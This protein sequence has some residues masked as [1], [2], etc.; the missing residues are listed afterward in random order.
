MRRKWIAEIG[1]CGQLKNVLTYQC[2]G[3]IEHMQCKQHHRQVNERVDLKLLYWWPCNFFQPL[4]HWTES[5]I[6]CFVLF[7]FQN[8]IH[9]EC[10]R[11][12][13]HYTL[14]LTISTAVDAVKPYIYN[15]VKKKKKIFSICVKPC[16]MF[17]M[18]H[19]H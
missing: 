7:D 15:F 5:Y 4:K 8:K 10:E 18:I 6:S 11:L 13:T 17:H 12:H 19:E 14:T 16:I 3:S 2:T 9:F 1:V